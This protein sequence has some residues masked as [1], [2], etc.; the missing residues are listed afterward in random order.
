VDGWDGVVSR[1]ARDGLVFWFGGSFG[2]GG[3]AAAMTAGVWAGGEG[4]DD[5]VVGHGCWVLW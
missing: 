1:Y 3:E 4:S 2:W 5:G